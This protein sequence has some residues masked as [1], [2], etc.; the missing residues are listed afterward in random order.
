MTN[1]RAKGF[2]SKL[3]LGEELAELDETYDL[4]QLAQGVSEQPES[5]ADLRAVAWLRKE[6]ADM[7][8]QLLIRRRP[9][10]CSN[11]AQA[12]WSKVQMVAAFGATV[13]FG[14][15]LGQA[16]FN[17]YRFPRDRNA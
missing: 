14:V 7:H 9:M 8:E 1:I 3:A 13:L 15:V 17:K 10:Q 6:V 11:P 12:D 4:Q 2:S 5:D 16:R